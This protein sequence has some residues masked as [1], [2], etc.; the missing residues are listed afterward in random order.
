MRSRAAAP[1][2]DRWTSRLVLR[3]QA[4]DSDAF[5]IL[6]GRYFDRIRDFLRFKL[7][8]AAEAEDVAQEVF[9]SALRGLPRYERR[10]GVPFRAWLF[11]IARNAAH[12]RAQR[13]ARVEVLAPQAVEALRVEVAQGS[14]TQEAS[15][16]LD[17]LLAHAVRLQPSPARE[18]LFLRYELDL[19]FGEIARV[20]GISEEAAYKQ[21]QRALVRLRT[22]FHPAREVEPRRRTDLAFRARS[23]MW[24][25]TMSSFV[26]LNGSRS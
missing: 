26:P 10:E 24:R 23:G 8:D 3:A 19:T 21:H 20:Q 22:H 9:A 6:Y 7:S 16:P 4:G 2:E 15:G 1:P 11:V 12:D 13:S 5:A 25:R 17:G 18:L 14:R